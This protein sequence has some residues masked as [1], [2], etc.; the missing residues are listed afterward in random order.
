MLR[1]PTASVP[2]HSPVL[3]PRTL[4]GLLG[5]VI[6][7]GLL[8]VSGT[9]ASI[10]QV[11][12]GQ[13]V[14]TPTYQTTV[15]ERGNLVVSVTATGPISAANTL[16]LNFKTS[17]QL[18]DIKVNVGDQVKKGQVL[19]DLDTTDLKI[20][21]DQANSN[22]AQAQAALAKLEAGATPAQK[23]VAQTSINGAE[24]A[25]SDAQASLANTQATSAKS[26]GVAQAS[27]NAAE[28]QLAAAQAAVASAQDQ[29]NK[30]IA[31]D[32][33]AIANAQKNLDSTKAAVAANIPILENQYEKAKD[34]LYAAQTSR[35]STCGHGGGSA[36]DSANATVAGAETEV[37]TAAAQLRQGQVQGQQQIQQ[38]QAQ[39]DQAK[40]QLAN[41]QSKLAAAVLS[42]QNQVKQDQ[43]SVNS[44]QSSL[45][46]AEAQATATVQT[47]QS[48]VNQAESGLKSAQANYDQV[49]APPTQADIDAAK[50]QVANAQAAVQAAKDNLAAATLTAPFDATVA[51]ING[52]VGQYVSG[53]A[54]TS[55]DA[56][57]TLVSLD[58][59]Q[60]TAQVNEADIAKVAVGDPVY[61][62]VSAFPNK[63]FRGKVTD[64][65]PVGT[66]V[67]NVVNYN[68]TSSIQSL[69][70]AK[71]LPGM[72]ATVNIISAQAN[73]VLLVPNSALSFAVTAAR[74]GLVSFPGSRSSTPNGRPPSA[75]GQ[76]GQ[77]Q[78][79]A[80]NRTGNGG[81]R[82]RTGGQTG[83]SSS[84]QGFGQGAG[85]TP[86]AS[87]S[88][89][90]FVLLLKDNHLQPVPV[91]T[92]I[93]DGSSTQ[94]ISGLTGGETIVV[95]QTGGVLAP[96][97]SGSPG[98]PG[99]GARFI[100]GS[101][102]AGGLR[103]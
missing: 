63:T 86:V 75:N 102:F 45:A 27:V 103:G 73:N 91:T 44:A 62:T 57:F 78:T 68:V 98:G 15:V 37:N 18:A 65:Q 8:S 47:A 58:D 14:A 31:A 3:S 77:G 24:S 87:S 85:A 97:R 19:A 94:I 21:L 93:T 36:C 6:V 72:T 30:A 35:D 41:D 32:Q 88:N 53:G 100:G 56:L 74:S 83:N 55:S 20:A 4:A 96:A 33:V 39:L 54:T 89:R 101:P 10:A 26:I 50:A 43:A 52:T 70:D 34:D 69:Q 90:A 51:S 64:I 79:G 40:A 82:F 22:L 38:A 25:L 95:G 11:L 5:L 76:T 59:L 16:P 80:Q 17:G 48:Q 7:V 60:V 13:K 42:A 46:Q 92:G 61:F 81:Q 1:L 9:L 23:E 99:N 84:S 28:T 12:P 71:L 2:H 66:V 49:V 29:E 67:Q